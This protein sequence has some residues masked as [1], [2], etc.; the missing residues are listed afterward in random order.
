M[1]L[2]IMGAGGVG[3]Y[4][5]ARFAEAG[6][7]VTFV[8]R[9][10]HKDAI[11]TNGL[12]VT[13]QRGDA[14]IRPASVTDDPATAGVCDF[15]FVCT[16]LGDLEA[17]VRAVRPAVGPD[18]GVVAF[19]NGVDKER[20]LREILGDGPV[21]GGV[22]HIAATIGEPGVIEHTGVMAS[23]TY[24]ELGGRKSE[25]LQILDAA[26]Q[27]APGFDAVCSDDIELAIWTK[28][29]F[30]APFAGITC[31]HR[32]PIGPIREDAAKRAQFQALIE[33]AVAVGRAEGVAFPADRAA[34]TLS[35]S[36]GLPHEMKSSMLHDLERGNRLELDWL[37]GAV[38][39]LGRQ[40]GIATPE[41]E[42]VYAALAQHK[43]G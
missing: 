39:R 29:V 26:A 43:D 10:R 12:R 32:Q 28:F 13:S 11:E 34:E 17:A 20:I 25:R 42:R 9:G 35:F 16:K 3:G 19:Q 2:L 31:Y 38:V 4:F 41:S 21:L 36:D 22:A 7:D 23:L 1:K 6:H 5:G 30:L 27:A 24:G 14:L 8:A 33:E 40:H 18:T 37:T 15:V